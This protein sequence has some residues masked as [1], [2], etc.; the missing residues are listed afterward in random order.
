MNLIFCKIGV[1][2]RRWELQSEKQ[3]ESLA[4][5][6][7]PALFIL[8]YSFFDES[9]QQIAQ[10]WIFSGGLVVLFPTSPP[11]QSLNWKFHRRDSSEK[12]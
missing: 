5:R 8:F 11:K 3:S 4:L 9:R 10:P 6:S 12:S 2:F 7:V 1:L